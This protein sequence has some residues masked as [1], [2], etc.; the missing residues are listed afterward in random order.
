MRTRNSNARL[1]H[2]AETTGKPMFIQTQNARTFLHP[3]YSSKD[4]LRFPP[5]LTSDSRPDTGKYL[6]CVAENFS[7]VHEYCGAAALSSQSRQSPHTVNDTC[8][9]TLSRQFVSQ[10]QKTTMYKRLHF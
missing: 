2:Q 4:H 10:L 6:L 9:F 1:T 7:Q 5:V 8:G 3:V